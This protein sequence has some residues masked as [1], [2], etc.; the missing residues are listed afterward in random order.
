MGNAEGPIL[1]RVPPWQVREGAQGIYY[2]NESAQDS[3]W[4]MPPELAIQQQE[5]PPMLTAE[6]HIEDA[7]IAHQEAE[8]LI[9]TLVEYMAE[10]NLF[11]EDP[12]RSMEELVDTEDE[13]GEV[14]DPHLAPP[15]PHRPRPTKVVHPSSAA[16]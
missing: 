7:C 6:D 3:T 5:A 4:S 9:D 15:L 2:Y 11:H 8:L 14:D 16:G 13:F 12:P 10:E 1:R